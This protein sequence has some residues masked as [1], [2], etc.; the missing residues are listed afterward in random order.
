MLDVQ[1]NVKNKKRFIVG[2][3]VIGQYM[4]RKFFKK[5]LISGFLGAGLFSCDPPVFPPKA[6]VALNENKTVDVDTIKVK[7]E[8]TSVYISSEGIV[9]PHRKI[10][11]LSEVK[12]RIIEQSPN[13]D[14]GGLLSEG[15]IL[16]KLDPRDYV[17]DVEK[18]RANVEKAE[19]ELI[20][21][22]GKKLVA[23]KEWQLLDPSFKQGGLGKNLALR[24]PHLREKEAALHAAQSSLEKS[25]VDLKRTLIRAPFNSLVLEEFV[26]KGQ[27]ILPQAK[28][29]ELVSTDEFRIQVSV[30]YD[31]LSSIFPMMKNSKAKIPVKVIE[32][33]GSNK[34]LER[35]GYVLRLLGGVDPN[36]RLVQVLIVVEDP[37]NIEN[38]DTVQFPLL[39]GAKVNVQFG[40]TEVTGAVKVPKSTIHEDN[41]IWIKNKSNKLEIKKVNILSEE[42]DS[43][44]ISGEG[45]DDGD[46][47]ITSDIPVASPGM[48]LHSRK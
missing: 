27:I 33:L 43:V 21:E 45:F 34:K 30:P 4:N 28:I 2:F 5:Y 10:T 35:E 7:K 11:V 38:H 39:L 14:A 22:K 19:F 8:N 42:G 9:K 20:L 36:G 3:K 18:N 37:L 46:E 32:D 1:K 13:L 17:V 26:E 40:S 47:I 12:G 29:A 31:E 16:L 44:Y 15:E 23:E 6:E 25:L 48:E 41:K 24:I